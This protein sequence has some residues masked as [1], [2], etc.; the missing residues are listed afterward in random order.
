MKIRNDGKCTITFNGGTL[1]PKQVAV[2]KGDAEKVG[3]VLLKNYKFLID[4]DNLKEEVVEVKTIEPVAEE[5]K[6]EI[7]SPRKTGK[8]SRK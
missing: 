1:A 8:K 7:A 6:E 5:P 4:L 2:F 3:E